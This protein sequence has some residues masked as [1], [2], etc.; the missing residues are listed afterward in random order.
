MRASGALICQGILDGSNGTDGYNTAIVSLYRRSAS[1][2]TN[3]DRPTGQ[4]TYT[5]STGEVTGQASYFNSWSQSIPAVSAGTKLY[6]IMAIARSQSGTDGI[7][8]TDWSTPVEYVSDGT[9][10]A[11]VFIYKRYPTQPT[12]KPADG[13]VY[14]FATGALTGTLNGWSTNIPA[15]DNNH[16]PCW[17]RQAMAVSR[18]T[19]DTINADEWSNP[20]T[21]LVEDGAS[22][23]KKSETY[24][25]ATNNTGV[26]PAANSADWS[27]TKPTLQKG[28]WL[29]TETTITW[30]DDSTTVLYTAE[31]N[32]NDGVSGQDIIVDGAT[33]M[34]YYVGDN[35]STHPAED[36][37]DWKD[38]SQVTQTKGKWLWSKA[39]TYYRKA[40]SSAGA[41]DAG[42]TVTYNVTYIAL[43]GNTPEAARGIES[44]TEYYKATNSSSAMSAPTSDDG[45]STD[46][47]LSDL[48]NKWGESYK[49]LWNFEKVTYNKAPLVERTIPQIVA[50]WTK[51]GGT[52][53]A[54]RGIDS[55]QNYYKVTNS[56]TAPS[57]PSTPG[58][59]GWST[60]PT[61]PGKGQYLWNYEVIT[62]I[63]PSGTTETDVQ[64]IG[65]AGTNGAQGY[66]IALTLIRNNLYTDANWNTYAAIGHNE[67][68]T[69]RTGDS[70][71]TACRVGDYF[72][73]T[74]SSSDTGK[75][76]TA[77][78]KCTSVES[79]II[80]GD[81]VSHTNDGAKGDNAVTYDIVLNTAWAKV[82]TNGC[83]TASLAGTAYKIDGSTRSVLPGATIRFGYIL[84]DSN[85]YTEEAADRFGNF[86]AGTWFDGHYQSDYAK[87]SNNIFAAIVIDGSVKCVKYVTIANQGAKGDTG[88]MFYL[89]GEWNNST[90][91]TRDSKVCPI[92][93][94]KVSGVTEEYWYL[95]AASAQG[96]NQKP[97]DGSTIWKKAENFGVVLTEALFTNFAKLGSGIV[98]GDWIISTYGEIDGDDYD[99]DDTYNGILGY[100][101]FEPNCPHS[102]TQTTRTINGQTVTGYNFLPVYAVNLKT[103]ECYMNDAYVSGTINSYSG[104]IGGF[105]ITSSAIS[106][107]NG[108]IVLNA[109][110]SATFKNV[111]AEGVI[112]ATLIYSPT[113]NAVQ[114]EWSIVP[115]FNNP[116]CYFCMP[117]WEGST[118][119]LPDPTTYDGLELSF[120]TPYGTRQ[121]GGTL[122]KKNSDH[123][124][125]GIHFTPH[126][127]VTINGETYYLPRTQINM[128]YADKVFLHYNQIV[129]VRAIN[130]EWYV[131]D[132]IVEATT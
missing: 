84:N 68:Y 71:L 8:T 93:H 45:W 100:L 43:D 111:T 24:R 70:D 75:K 132:G 105:K 83:I 69:K 76:H 124:Y 61:A 49:Y 77:I 29:F 97:A 104:R 73:V 126:D 112:K 78:Y 30:S 23:T 16:Y 106:A 46:P 102:Q 27:T 37:N 64:M 113:A 128:S 48:T 17:V 129:R 92:V 94:C 101:W 119:V 114:G 91:Y 66:S 99:E 62:W 116:S 4:L 33:V 85:T 3:S 63:N 20:A 51:D 90:R 107:N 131:T 122:L 9:S 26:C 103:G 50:I 57:K 19:T 31:R 56:S 18:G 125:D 60:T 55:I 74:G 10:S 79:N 2:L 80:Y 95:D 87:G 39:T 38:L 41:H 11:P 109:N 59:G 53:G 110:G 22:I 15:T 82:D 98:S 34:K 21:K 121:T 13:A 54:G 1:V 14:T 86:D 130:G 35:N 108:N 7:A 118:I 81:C 88:R 6:V 127:A 117:G 52:G 42:Y 58:T 5:F 32:P 89:A 67:S 115:S 40:S 25:Y 44:V 12:D 28:Y 123:S 120:L 96:D 65:Y 36:S 47:N 72:V